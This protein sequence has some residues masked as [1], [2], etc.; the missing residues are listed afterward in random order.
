[1]KK[2][3]LIGIMILWVSVAFAKPV[4]YVQFVSHNENS[5]NTSCYNIDTDHTSY[6]ANRTEV[7][8]F[9]NMIISKHAAWD[10]QTSHD[11]LDDVINWD[12]PAVE[13]N[14][15]G[16]NLIKWLSSVNMYAIEVDAHSHMS[17][18]DGLPADDYADVSYMI[19]LLGGSRNGVVGGFIYYP[20]DQ[21]TWPQFDSIQYGWLY[22]SATFQGTVLWGAA[23][24]DHQCVNGVCDDATAGVW[25]PQDAYD[26]YTDSSSQSLDY[27]GNYGDSFSNLNNLLSLLHQGLLPDG[28]YTASIFIEQCTLTDTIISSAATMIDDVAPDVAAGNLIW[29]PLLGVQHNWQIKGSVPVIYSYQ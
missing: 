4:I 8:R 2:I 29:M 5:D 27:I 15:G 7:V 1:M 9:A 20:W 18:T 24:Y 26:F 28:I 23:V 11:F 25:R 10:M 3:F 19:G 21:A 17:R 12:V 13:G 16:E 14:T 6:I 22:P